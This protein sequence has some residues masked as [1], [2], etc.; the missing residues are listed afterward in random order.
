MNNFLVI[1]KNGEPIAALSKEN[2]SAIFCNEDGNTDIYLIG[3]EVPVPT[4]MKFSTVCNRLGIELF[5]Y[6]EKGVEDEK[7]MP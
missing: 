5:T 6:K 3:D 4:H 1:E 2:I 7:R